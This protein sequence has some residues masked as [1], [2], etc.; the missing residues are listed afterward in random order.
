MLNRSRAKRAIYGSLRWL[1]PWTSGLDRSHASLD[2][3]QGLHPLWITWLTPEQIE[4][5]AAGAGIPRSIV[6]SMTL[7]VYDGDALKLDPK[8]RRLDEY[9]PFG[10]V[11]FRAFVPSVS[12]SRMADGSCSGGSVG[13]SP[14]F[15][16]TR[17][18]LTSGA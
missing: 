8:T 4:A 16:T 13:R 2:F 17:S 10:A 12:S 6:E 5:I 18:C 9:I 7:S 1:E 15:G 11:G 3:P 14:V